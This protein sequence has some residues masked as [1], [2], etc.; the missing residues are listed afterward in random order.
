M[1]ENPPANNANPTN[2]NRKTTNRNF[3]RGRNRF[4]A[5]GPRQNT[6]SVPIPQPSSIEPIGGAYQPS[7]GPAP[8]SISFRIDKKSG[9][10]SGW[11]LYFPEIGI[12][13]LNF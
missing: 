4:H 3:F 7:A 13:F 9:P 6:V 8:Q 12:L 10:Y 11:K 1:A 2:N 5:T